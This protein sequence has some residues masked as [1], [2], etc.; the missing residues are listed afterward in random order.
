MQS[1]WEYSQLPPKMTFNLGPVLFS[2]FGPRS[3]K[4]IHCIWLCLFS[5]FYLEQGSTDFFSKGQLVSIRL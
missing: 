5:A 4:V 2:G 3:I 1:N